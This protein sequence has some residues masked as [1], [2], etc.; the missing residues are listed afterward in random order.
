MNRAVWMVRR[1]RRTRVRPRLITRLILTAV[2][3]AMESMRL[4]G[5][6]RSRTPSTVWGAAESRWGITILSQKPAWAG[7]PQT[8]SGELAG[9]KLIGFM[10][11]TR[12][13][14]LKGDFTGLW[15]ARTRPATIG[16]NFVIFGRTTVG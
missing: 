1:I 6:M 5:V 10:R 16:Y 13:R 3:G 4:D 15:S 8:R 14:A 12:R 11:S 2:L 7:F 9:A